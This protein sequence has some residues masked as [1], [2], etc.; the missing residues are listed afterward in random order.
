MTQSPPASISFAKTALSDDNPELAALGELVVEELGISGSNDTLGRWMAHRLAELLLAY[1]DSDPGVTKEDAAKAVEDLIFR[2]WSH[3]AD[4]RHRWPPRT[5]QAVEDAIDPPRF[6]RDP[7]TGIGWLD[8]YGDLIELQREEARLWIGAGLVDSGVASENRAIETVGDD[9]AFEERQ[10]FQAL[11]RLRDETRERMKDQV[12]S[13]K[14][15]SS[16]QKRAANG[17]RPLIEE[18][19]HQHS[20][21]VDSVISSAG[22]RSRKKA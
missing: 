10:R 20:Q 1:E 18:L 2:I 15:I 22:Q 4:H 16:R 19:N 21:L 13:V 17:M 12:S 5:S 9:V 14:E 8:R 6:D 3:R 11:T 7:P